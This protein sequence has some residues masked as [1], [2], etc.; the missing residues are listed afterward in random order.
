MWVTR[1]YN[2]ADP[3]ILSVDE[4]D[5]VTIKDVALAVAKAH[6]FEGKIEFDTSKS[7]GQHKKT[8]CNKKLRKYRPDYKFTSMPDGIKQSVDWFVANY[9]TCRK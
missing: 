6:N 1:E 2:E 9:D 7:D 4:E 3:I 5:E 8:A